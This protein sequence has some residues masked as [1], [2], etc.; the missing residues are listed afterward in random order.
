MIH[1]DGVD[2]EVDLG[3]PSHLQITG[4][5]TV[6][7]WVIPDADQN[8]EIISKL[9]NVPN[10]GFSLQTEPDVGEPWA[11]FVIATDGSTTMSS[12]WT[13]SSMDLN[14]LY[15]LVGVFEPSVAVRI[16]QNGVLHNE[17]TTG[18]PATQHDPGNNVL[19][20][21]RPDGG[22]PFDGLVGDGRIYGRAM[23]PAEIATI[24]A[25][26]GFDGI[27]NKLLGRWLLNEA[28]AGTASGSTMDLSKYQNHGTI[29]NSPTWAESRLRFRRR[30]FG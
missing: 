6:M 20:G 19:I 3:N 18:V 15:H 29:N 26:R 21:R 10:R 14:T 11:Q 17:N 27:W 1:F 24:Y 12:G 23:G 2:S 25:A 30:V 16:Y 28:A 13:L 4:P 22:G 7:A 8:T 5:M 9:G